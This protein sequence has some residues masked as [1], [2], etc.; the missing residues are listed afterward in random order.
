VVIIAAA[1]G[2]VLVYSSNR[3]RSFNLD[4]MANELESRS[5]LVALQIAPLV[6]AGDHDGI[7]QSCKTYGRLTGTRLTVIDTAG[8]VLGDSDEDPAIMENHGNRPEV[9]AAYAKGPGMNIRFSNTLQTEMMY[10]AVPFKLDGVTGGVIRSSL[11]VSEIQHTLSQ[12]NRNVSLIGVIIIVL[13][14]VLSFL[15]FR[16]V[17]LSLADL[18]AGANRFADGEFDTL[19]PAPDIA[20]IGDLADAMNQMAR[21]LD[22]RIRTIVEQRNTLDTVLTGMTDALIAV[23]SEERV[24]DLNPSACRLLRLERDDSRG[25][26]VQELFRG[27]ELLEFVNRT[28]RTEEPVSGKIVLR[29]EQERHLQAHGSPLISADGR[30]IGGVIVL[31]DLT[32]IYKLENIRREFV[33]NV[34]HELKTPITSIKGFVETVLDGDEQLSSESRRFLER[35][36]NQAGRL[37]LIIED[38]LA[39]SRLEHAEDEVQSQLELLAIRPILEAAVVDFEHAIQEKKIAVEIECN[40]DIQARV[41]FTLIEQAVGNLLDNAIRFSDPESRIVLRGKDLLREVQIEVQDYGA[42]IEKRHIDR[43]FERFYRVDRGRSRS[44]GGSGLGLALVKHIVLS[45]QG[46]V[47]VESEPGKGSTFRIHL[48]KA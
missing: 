8:I 22:A 26:P 38:L 39:L 5:Q 45:H 29:R 18:Q 46:H 15:V 47:T 19:L 28:L 41:S 1:I 23:D 44:V 42:G 10:V 37:H 9:I 3:F 20:E 13:V 17:T 32:A 21:Q 33:S 14:I 11:P 12:I 4:R 25:K 16:R 43:L 30:R 27:A 6:E 24:I 35:V 2:F 31:T 34:S 36:V 40:P 48:P 7:D